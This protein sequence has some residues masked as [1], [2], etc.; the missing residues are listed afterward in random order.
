LYGRAS[1]SGTFDTFVSLIFG[2]D[3][4]AFS[5]RLHVKENGEAIANAV[6]RDPAGIGYVGIAQIRSQKA[7]ELSDGPGTASLLPSPFTV[8]TEDYI[9]SRRLF[10]YTP[11]NRDEFTRK[12][13]DFAL[14]PQ[15][16]AVMEEVGFVRQTPILEKVVNP[17]AAPA[18]YRDRVAG[19]RRMS[20]NFRFRPNSTILDNKALADLP[21]AL[22]VLT[23]NGIHANVAV[24]GFADSKGTPLQNQ[25][26]SVQRAEVVGERLRAYGIEVQ[27]VGFSSVMPVGDNATPEGREKNRRVEVW[28]P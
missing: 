24:L 15:G 14:G 17:P 16:Q 18:S 28:A 1:D 22:A 13:I 20:L 6:S 5:P 8:A 19:L 21:R 25:T 2:G 7:L 4:N 3:K 11:E 12:F 9:L 10:F 23:Q 26:L 27:T